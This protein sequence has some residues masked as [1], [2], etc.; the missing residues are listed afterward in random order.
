MY[1]S[2]GQAQPTARFKSSRTLSSMQPYLHVLT[3][4]KK[5]FVTTDSCNYAIGVVM[6]QNH[7][8]GRHHVA[9]I[10]RTFNL[11]EKNYAAHDLELLGIVDTLKTWRSYLY[12]QKFVVH[13]DYHPLKYLETQESL[14]PRQVRW[15]E[16][17]SMFDYDIIPIRGKSNQV[18][19]GLS[20][21]KSKTTGS[22]KY[23]KGLLTRVMQKTSV[24]G[25]MQILVP[26]SRL[27]KMLISEYL[28]DQLFNELLRHPKEPFEVRNGF[29]FPGSRLCIPD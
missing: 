17:V 26:G 8:N 4:I 21:Q 20:K 3:Q 29:L 10:S 16:R 13:T 5:I 28:P 15:F 1:H 12:G 23:P 11:H 22:S 27:T 2:I 14:T 25:A 18:A 7:D 19:N 6:E 9:F 24:M